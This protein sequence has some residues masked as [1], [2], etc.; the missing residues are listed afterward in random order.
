MIEDES[1]GVGGNNGGISTIY[2][3]SE[4]RIE[5]FGLELTIRNRDI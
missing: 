4:A 2:S 1:P 5:S 3:P